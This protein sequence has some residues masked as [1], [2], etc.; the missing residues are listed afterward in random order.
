[1]INPEVL[2]KKL[3][4]VPHSEGGYFSESFRDKKGSVSLI[5]Y[6]L[7]K[8]EVSQWHRL[9]K[10]EIL[11][12]YDGDPIKIYLSKD[13]KEVSHIVLGRD[14]ESRQYF[15]YVVESETWFGMKS[16]GDW[17]LI[18]CTVSPAFSYEDF[19]LASKEWGIEN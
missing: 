10:N 7:K 8:N 13:K 18:G 6:L 16:T 11:H 2:I 3:K 19:E 4:L 17:S 15:H 5:Y 14:L 12:F 1:M 9:K